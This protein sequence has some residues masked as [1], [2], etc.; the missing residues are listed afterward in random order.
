MMLYVREALH[1]ISKTAIGGYS[2]DV[3]STRDALTLLPPEIFPQ[4][5]IQR[6]WCIAKN[7]VP[8][9]LR[10]YPRRHV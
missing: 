2:A 6:G 8:N 9:E 10:S 5:T 3:D 7:P 4:Y 1:S